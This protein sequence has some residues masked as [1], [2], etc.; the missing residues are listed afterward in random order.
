MSLS[1]TGAGLLA[2][3]AWY[4]MSP[5][6]QN[7]NT[8]SWKSSSKPGL[9]EYEVRS[10]LPSSNTLCNWCTASADVPVSCPMVDSNCMTCFISSGEQRV[11]SM[12]SNSCRTRA[13]TLRRTSSG[14]CLRTLSEGILIHGS[15]MSR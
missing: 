3:Q 13:N 6:C 14:I 7:P 2:G 4:T 8:K 5:F 10:I 1:S 12:C 11:S 9:H 15:R